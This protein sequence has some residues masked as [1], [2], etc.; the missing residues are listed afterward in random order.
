MHLKTLRNFLLLVLCTIGI[1]FASAPPAKAALSMT[2]GSGSTIKEDAAIYMTAVNNGSPNA[3][4]TNSGYRKCIIKINK[5]G[6]TG[7][8]IPTLEIDSRGTDGGNP[9]I[10]N[11][12]TIRRTAQ[13]A[14]S[15]TFVIY[16]VPKAATTNKARVKI[17]FPCGTESTWCRLLPVWDGTN[18]SSVTPVFEGEDPSAPAGPAS[19]ILNYETLWMSSPADAN[20]KINSALEIT[21]TNTTGAPTVSFGSHSDELSAKID[22]K[23]GSTYK[24]TITFNGKRST[25][26]T[27][28]VP[29][30]VSWN[31]VTKNVT[32]KLNYTAP[33]TATGSFEVIN[34]TKELWLGVPAGTISKTNSFKVKGTD[35][36]G[37][38]T[39]SFGSRSDE[40]KAEWIHRGGT[41]YQINVTYTPKEYI[42]GTV[43]VPMT[44]SMPNANN[45]ATITLKL[46]HEKPLDAKISLSQTEFWL[47]AQKGQAEWENNG[48]IKRDLTV[49]TDG[50]VAGNITLS[51]T[52]MGNYGL[53]VIPSVLPPEG[54]KVVIIYQ[55]K[56]GDVVHTFPTL[57]VKAVNAPEVT[58]TLKTTYDNSSVSTGIPEPPTS[59]QPGWFDPVIY[60]CKTFPGRNTVSLRWELKNPKNIEL[61]Y[62]YT[63]DPEGSDNRRK[64]DKWNE[65]YDYYMATTF[66]LYRDGVLVVDNL[67]ITSYVD[68]DVTPGTHKYTVKAHYV[69]KWRVIESAEA[70]VDVT[71]E[72]AISSYVLEEVYNYPIVDKATYDSGKI[73]VN[74]CFQAFTRNFVSR[75]G[76]G[77]HREGFLYKY[78]TFGNGTPTDPNK[79]TQRDTGAPGDGVRQAVFRDGKWYIAMVTNR[80]AIDF[81]GSKF[82]ENAP[83]DLKTNIDRKRDALEF[84]IYVD[85]DANERGQILELEARNGVNNPLG[86]YA[87]LRTMSNQSLA[88]TED[89][90]KNFY[91]RGYNGNPDDKYN[92][93]NALRLGLK[94][95]YFEGITNFGA[96]LG[97]NTVQKWINYGW[98]NNG[99]TNENLEANLDNNQYYRTHYMAARGKVSEGNAKLCFAQNLSHDAY[100]VD[101]NNQGAPSGYHKISAPRVAKAKGV[102]ASGNVTDKYVDINAGTEN[103][104]FPVEGEPNKYIHV[105]RSSGIFLVDATDIDNPVYTL[106]TADQSEVRSASGLTFTLYNTWDG[107]TDLFYIHGTSVHSN[108]PGHFRIDMPQR[109]WDAANK[110]YTGDVHTADFTNMV[111]MASKLQAEIPGFDAGNSNGMS[112]GVE[113]AVEDGIAVKYIYQYVPGVRF[114]KYKFYPRQNFPSVQPDIQVIVRHDN[115]EYDK[116]STKNKPDENI[117][118]TNDITH[119][120]VTYSWK[121]PTDFDVTQ[122]AQ[123]NFKVAGYDVKLIDPLGRVLESYTIDDGNTA[124][125]TH[126]YNQ[127]AKPG[128][129]KFNDFKD[130]GKDVND[131]N[132]FKLNEVYNGKYTVNVTPK[133]KSTSSERTYFGETGM[134]QH[135]TDYTPQI[136]NIRAKLWQATGNTN[137]YRVDIDFNRAPRTAAEAA[138]NTVKQGNE[139]D[140]TYRLGTESKAMDYLIAEPV[141]RFKI[142]VDKGDGNG[143]QPISN[144]RIV[145]DGNVLYN[146]NDAAEQDEAKRIKDNFDKYNSNPNE[147]IHHGTHDG[148]VKHDYNF[149]GYFT[150][151]RRNVKARAGESNR[152]DKM[153]AQEANFIFYGGDPSKSTEVQDLVNKEKQAAEGGAFPVVAYHMVDG[154]KEDISNLYNWTYR[155]TAL[156]ADNQPYESI[157]RDASVQTRLGYPSTTGI[158]DVTADAEN[159]GVHIWPVPAE[160][161][162]HISASEAIRTVS[163][164]NISGACVAT[165]EGNN[166]TA[167]TVNVDNLASG[168]YLVK[169]NANAAQRLIK[170]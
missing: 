98:R 124:S 55:P 24:V 92:G 8:I 139:V 37:A 135:Q 115:P 59:F 39:F 128:S 19:F 1:G 23:S 74:K 159:A 100:I 38:P 132:G 153:Y 28:N 96:C 12:F 81:N 65:Y 66:D 48:R 29:M 58:A 118:L 18:K 120:D 54:G 80:A 75:D 16:Y 62:Y 164:F 143:F 129:D 110:Q 146:P 91:F 32:I 168:V 71:R 56:P 114:A 93:T 61:K 7:K 158:D 151:G 68:M 102:D 101:L 142:E 117:H 13:D 42:S 78:N 90:N 77:V 145:Y 82:Q 40:L 4:Y 26:G 73:D 60:E 27:E 147:S 97:N 137:L 131:H 31:G 47:T 166:D 5:G 52:P 88:I 69:N 103:Y 9:N 130:L 67:D 170:R 162:L 6:A 49:T 64:Q 155:A 15:E 123:P 105:M 72:N 14:S 99:W 25:N 63:L 121:R 79:K 46:Q 2:D 119:F 3:E 134:A 109:T 169:V 136:Y 122:G 107:S 33:V 133:Y 83:T 161:E 44:V 36:T 70:S 41:E 108:N 149:G 30:T 104:I 10:L 85:R 89:A 152:G 35:T 76:N 111:P 148:Y 94:Q 144:L 150:N 95:R 17:N 11:E 51:I 138:N 50:K 57:K 22:L 87:E 165:F 140:F 141:S 156:Y 45:N 20:P 154:S 160:S 125:F 43:D 34:G 106:I 113:D 127:H 163:I 86:V 53:T 116:N 112:F 21:G 126:T 157:K 167:M 84:G